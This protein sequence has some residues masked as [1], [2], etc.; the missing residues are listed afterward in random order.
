M[1]APKPLDE[2]RLRALVGQG[3]TDGRI[4]AELEVSASAVRRARVRLGLPAQPASRPAK[5]W[6]AVFTLRMTEG[7]LEQLHERAKAAGASSTQDYAH[8]LIFSSDSP[9]GP[10]C[11]G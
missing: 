3:W 11:D 5:G 2:S 9:D 1:T 10:S 4:A 7:E 8:A 6:S